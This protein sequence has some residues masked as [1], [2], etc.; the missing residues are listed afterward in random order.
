MRK[1]KW[2]VNACIWACYLQ[3]K[4]TKK[5]P[6]TSW[7][8]RMGRHG[9]TLCLHLISAHEKT[10]NVSHLGAL[11]DGRRWQK[12]GNSPTRVSLWWCQSSNSE[13]VPLFS[14]RPLPLSVSRFFSHSVFALCVKVFFEKEKFWPRD[15]SPPHPHPH[16]RKKN[17]P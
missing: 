2:G 12:H 10:G 5:K 15:F 14:S 1:R 4:K 3:I 13:R 8:H 9:L 7:K 11:K 6:P 17:K 16:P